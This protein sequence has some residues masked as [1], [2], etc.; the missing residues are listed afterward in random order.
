M[1][2]NY[3]ILCNN[4]SFRA[5][6]N[7]AVNKVLMPNIKALSVVEKV[8]E[9][10]IQSKYIHVFYVFCIISDRVSLAGWIPIWDTETFFCVFELDKHLLHKQSLWYVPHVQCS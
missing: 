2:D 6:A 8:P 7:D 1:Y 4:Y 5:L 3:I 9:R 10:L